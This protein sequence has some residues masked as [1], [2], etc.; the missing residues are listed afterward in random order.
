MGVKLA[1]TTNS[2]QRQQL[3]HKSMSVQPKGSVYVINCSACPEVYVGQTGKA[4]ERRMGEHTKI[5][6]D[7][8]GAVHRHNAIPGHVLDLNNPTQVFS[9]DCYSTHITVEAALMH[10][11]PTVRGNTSSTSINSNKLVAPV[12]CRATKFNWNQMQYCI[13]QIKKDAVP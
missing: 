8:M 6:I 11:A 13:P 2:T 9:S 4:V 3:K 1:Y 10:A 5:Q 12:I 7:A